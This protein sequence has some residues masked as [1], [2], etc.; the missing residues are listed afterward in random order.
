MTEQSKA[1]LLQEYDASVKQLQRNTAIKASKESPLDKQRRI[2]K[3][4]SNYA[5]FF[6][7]YLSQYATA[8]TA[9]YHKKAA[10]L[11]CDNDI[12]YLIFEVYRSGAKSV[13]T[14]IGFPLYL[15]FTDRMRY[16]LLIGENNDK[17]DELL[18]HIQLQLEGNEL[19]INDYGK[20]LKYGSWAEG[21]FVTEKGVSFKA[22]GLGQSPRGTRNEEQR[23]DYIVADDLDTKERCRNPKR[24]QEAVDWIME[25]LLG[26]MDIG[27]QRFVLANNR[28][29]KNSILANLVKIFKQTNQ[30]LREQGLPETYHHIRVNAIKNRE[31]F[32]PTWPEN[33]QPIIGVLSFRDQAVTTNANT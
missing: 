9:A 26:T 15:M 31:T 25:D 29:H 28:I 11:V 30:K 33:I 6:E 17:A 27:R 19:I 4:K 16:M 1:K 21:D 5:D 7:Y 10:K 23:P 3:L 13:H 32:E 22:L 20:Q 12:S 14:T 2:K 18:S 8:K 24:V